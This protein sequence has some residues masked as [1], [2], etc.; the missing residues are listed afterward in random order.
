[1]MRVQQKV[2]GSFRSYEGALAFCRI[3][4]YIST[5]RKNG[6]S[7]IDALTNAFEKELALSDCLQTT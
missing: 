2:S 7:V 6:L 1:M 3:R 5:V 4:S